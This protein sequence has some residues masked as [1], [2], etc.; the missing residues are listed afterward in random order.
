MCLLS[1]LSLIEFVILSNSSVIV[2]PYFFKT[3][4]KT[5]RFTWQLSIPKII[6]LSKSRLHL[7]VFF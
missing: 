5:L 6:L 4:H 3:C 2:K 7:S 1:L